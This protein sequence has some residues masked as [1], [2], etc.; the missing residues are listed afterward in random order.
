MLLDTCVYLYM[1]QL[2]YLNTNVRG[3]TIESVLLAQ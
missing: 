1:S 2:I 3:S